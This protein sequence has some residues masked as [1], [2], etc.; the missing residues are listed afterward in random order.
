MVHP[1]SPV[2]V[3][4]V[5]V[6]GSLADVSH[7][8]IDAHTHVW[9]QP[10][11][12]T[13]AGGPTLNDPARSLVEIQAFAAAGGTALVDCQ[14]G[15]AGRDG[16]KL[17]WLSQASGVPIVACTGF[18]LR[19][20]YP[21]ESPLWSRGVD[22]LTELMVSELDPTLGLE[23]CRDNPQPVTAGFIKV[24]I[25]ATLADSPLAALSAAADAA[26]TTGA[27]VQIH[28]ERGAA[29]A[30]VVAFFMERGVT[31]R[32]LLVCHMDK[33]PDWG[34][35]VALAQAGVSLEYDTFFRPKYD[36][37][38][39]LWPLIDH[40]VAAGHASAVVLATDLADAAQWVSYG[41]GPGLAAFPTQIPAQLAARGVPLESIALLVGDN[42]TRLLARPAPLP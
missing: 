28:T 10:E 29:A 11:P 20:Y 30:E 6:L 23:E 19:R 21:A 1:G 41:G 39:K 9:I 42:I 37:E 13:P 17:A 35:H 40:M 26:T 3:R 2:D 33:R 24:A 22:D 38:H 7:G 16:Q 14:P 32:Q 15:G 36:P 8:R 18:H 5:S 34:L 12:G 31:P 27:A 25:E 4:I